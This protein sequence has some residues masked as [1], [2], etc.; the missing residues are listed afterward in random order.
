ME[1]DIG[2][3]DEAPTKL[4][5]WREDM[6]MLGRWAGALVIASG[7]VL[8]FLNAVDFPATFDS[9][10]SLGI[11]LRVFWTQFVKI[12]S[13]GVIIVLLAELV[14]VLRGPLDEED[15]QT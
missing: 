14:D 12:G 15:E 3:E 5:W 11:R 9:Q 7:L 13:W 2:I 4:P 10:G 6:P 8:A 1:D